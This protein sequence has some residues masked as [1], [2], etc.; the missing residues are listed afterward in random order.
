[1]YS[2]FTE[3]DWTRRFLLAFA[4]AHFTH[5]SDG[6]LKDDPEQLR[7][8]YADVLATRNALLKQLRAVDPENPLLKHLMLFDRNRLAG[9]SA[10]RMSGDDFGAA[11][12]MGNTFGVPGRE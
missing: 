2:A 6:V 11:R 1:V 3:S 7:E 4:F 5:F 10:F 9:I 8:V 12:D